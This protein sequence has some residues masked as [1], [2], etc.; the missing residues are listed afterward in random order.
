VPLQLGTQLSDLP[1]QGY[2]FGSPSIARPTQISHLG[3]EL[4]DPFLQPLV[5]CLPNIS[6]LLEKS[7]KHSPRAA[8]PTGLLG[9]F[10]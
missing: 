2:R 10:V 6:T 8:I 1:F 5:L 4:F 9:A 3:A 7:R